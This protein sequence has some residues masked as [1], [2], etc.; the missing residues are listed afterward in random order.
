MLTI[1]GVAAGMATITVTAT[2][3][4]GEIRY[5]DHHGNGGS[6]QHASH[7]WSA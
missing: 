6:S 7:R 4:D 1:T 3:M 5:A 2:D